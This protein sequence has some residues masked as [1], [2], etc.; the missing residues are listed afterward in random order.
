MK[1]SDVSDRAI[2]SRLYYACYHAAKAVL[3]DQGFNP[4]SHSG[5]VSRF[6]DEIMDGEKVTREDAKFLSKS[7]TRREQA[8]YEKS[9][10]EEDL[11]QLLNRTE[12]FVAKMK[13]LIN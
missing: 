9:P 4:K 5:L 7:Q 11:D 1:A 2:A 8:D 13:N 12:E 10:V 6:G 3:F